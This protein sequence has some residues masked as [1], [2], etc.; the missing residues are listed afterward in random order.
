ML[1]RFRTLGLAA[2]L[3]AIPLF[4]QPGGGSP[5]DPS[6][7]IKMRVAMLTAQLDLT[8]AQQAQATDIF[9]KAQTAAESIR[10]GTQSNRT[11]F[12]DAVKNNDTAAIDKL[13]A[14]AGVLNG[15][16]MAIQGKAEAA[17]Y[18]ILTT[19]QKTKYD[20]MP[21]GGPGGMGGMGGMGGRGMPGGGMGPAGHRPPM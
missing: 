11:S 17:F 15:Q 4:A 8:A 18:A 10:T 16:L 19:D 3:L 1:N 13:A 9:T 5:P 20:S 6:H 14:A 21:H 2:T 12:Q 7:M